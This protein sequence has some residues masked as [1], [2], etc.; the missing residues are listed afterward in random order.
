MTAPVYAEVATDETTRMQYADLFFWL[1]RH[2][3]TGRHV[4]GPFAESERAIPKDWAQKEKLGFPV[5]VVGWL[6]QD[7]YYA[8]I[9][10]WFTGPEAQRFFNVDELVKLLD[11][12]K[13][14]AADNTRKIWIVYMFLMWYRIYFVDR[15][16]PEKPTA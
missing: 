10:E 16:V 4:D 15:T 11:D 6:R 3:L 12:H 5:P 8:Q 1:G 13:S 9:K 2:P 7:R 14:G